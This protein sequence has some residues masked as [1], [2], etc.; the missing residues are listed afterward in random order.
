MTT[1]YPEHDKLRK[2]KDKSQEMG[3]FLDWLSST[4]IVLCKIHTHDEGCKDDDGD[5]Y[6]GYHEDEYTSIRVGPE[7]LLSEYFNIDL[8]K[9]EEEK[10]QM[11]EEIR[12]EQKR[13]F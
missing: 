13:R 12:N 7:Q 10:Q 2:V 11:L 4:N 6:C 5:N 8:K 3:Y 1:Q 9:L